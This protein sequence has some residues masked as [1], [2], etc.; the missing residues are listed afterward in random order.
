MAFM[1]GVQ[2]EILPEAFASELAVHPYV[3]VFQFFSFFFF[4]GDLFSGPRRWFFPHDLPKRPTGRSPNRRSGSSNRTRSFFASWRSRGGQDREVRCVGFGLQLRHDQG[5]YPR[6]MPVLK[7]AFIQV[8]E[9]VLELGVLSDERHLLLDELLLHF[10]FA[11]GRELLG[12]GALGDL[13][14]ALILRHR[15]LDRRRHVDGHAVQ[16]P[17]DIP[18]PAP[19]DRS[20]RRS[21]PVVPGVLVHQDKRRREEVVLR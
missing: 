2:A 14:E 4:A 20:R 16:R 7:A 19:G 9:F 15:D 5:L 13:F 12:A 18:L 6:E 21:R 17:R 1:A 3:Q 8:I 10:R 11:D